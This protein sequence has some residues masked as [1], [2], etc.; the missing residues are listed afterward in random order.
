[1]NTKRKDNSINARKTYT[2]K[3]I[4]ITVVDEFGNSA[5]KILSF[6]KTQSFIDRLKKL[7]K[8]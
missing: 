1:M 5:S 2:S 3:S 8:G 4:L 6:K 7:I